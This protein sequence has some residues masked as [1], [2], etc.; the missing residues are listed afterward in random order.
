MKLIKLKCGTLINAEAVILIKE[1][2]WPRGS[3]AVCHSQIIFG[4]GGRGSISAKEEAD[5]LAEIIR[6]AT[7]APKEILLSETKPTSLEDTLP[8]E[9]PPP[10]ISQR[11]PPPPPPPGPHFIRENQYPID[12]CTPPKPTQP[13]DI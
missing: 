2:H 5:E 1:D 10:P 3:E 8:G 9:N 7:E 11:P 6:K 12:R 13:D 4:S